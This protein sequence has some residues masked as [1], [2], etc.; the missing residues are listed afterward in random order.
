MFGMIEL[1]LGINGIYM[2][3]SIFSILT[4]YIFD[5]VQAVL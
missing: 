3:S 1:H 2:L 4:S 5:S